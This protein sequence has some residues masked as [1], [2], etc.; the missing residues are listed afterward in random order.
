MISMLTIARFTA[1]EAVR[2]RLGWLVVGFAIV[3]CVLAVFAGEVAIAETQGVRNGLLG[4]WLRLCAVFTVG[5]CVVSSVVRESHDKGLDLLLSMP[6]PRAAYLA[7]KLVGFAGVSI[8]TVGVCGLAV[9][10][11]APLAQAALWATSLSLELLI[12]TAMSLL[13][14]FTFSEVT[15]ALGTVIGFYV[16]SRSMAALQIMAR[17][18]LV[19]SASTAQ[20]FAGV[21]VDAL[22][23][24]LPDLDRF[25][26]SE[27]LIHGSGTIGDLG[28]VTMQTV[29][30]VALLFAAASFDLYRKAL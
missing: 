13:C 9:A 27:W 25:T 20:Q 10:W 29:I 22:A 14:A 26:E 23:F 21:L 12:V 19:E 30:Y 24:L 15:W 11:F 1:L 3:G 17:E 28:F 4:A 6:L 7:G 5:A 8:L 16:L 2:G 18:P